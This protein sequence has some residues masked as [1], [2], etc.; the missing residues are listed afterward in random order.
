[1][2]DV[3]PSMRLRSAVP[4]A[5]VPA[6]VGARLLAKR[7]KPGPLARAREEM[8]FLLGTVAPDRVEEAAR[9]YVVRDVMR[10]EMRYHPRLIC[11][12]EVQNLA[13]LTAARATGRGVVVSF[14]HHGHYEGASAALAAADRPLGIV[15]SPDMLGP[16]APTFLKQ[17]VR[18]G[19]STGNQP[20]DAGLG[21]KHLGGL[22]ARGECL[23]IATDVPGSSVIEFLGEKRLGSSGAARLAAA[24]NSLVVTMHAHCE[25]DGRLWLSLGDAVEPRDFEDAEDLLRH[26]VQTQEEHVLAWPEG[27]HQPRLRWGVPQE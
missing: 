27:Y 9:A 4:D 14:L 8:E 2:N 18:A 3:T 25:S 21:G 15:V 11:R 12:Q 16:A 20:I 17:H 19:T 10:S 13:S 23:A 22:L 26:L 6:V 7:N 5:L 24:T 1:M